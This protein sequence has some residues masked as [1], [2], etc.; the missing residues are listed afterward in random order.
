MQV[1]FS[2]ILADYVCNIFILTSFLKD[3]FMGYRILTLYDHIEYMIIPYIYP[4]Y[5]YIYMNDDTFPPPPFVF[6]QFFKDIIYSPIACTVSD[7]KSTMILNSDPFYVT[8]FS[9][10]LLL[11]FFPL[12]FVFSNMIIIYLRVILCLSC[13]RFIGVLIFVNWH[14]SSDLEN[15]EP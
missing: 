15:C 3:I 14:F 5:I 12:S 6:F 13:L 1:L 8:C 9:L 4:I 2:W 10:W 7:E 11:R